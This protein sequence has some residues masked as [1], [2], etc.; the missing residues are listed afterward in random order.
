MVEKNTPM[1]F[2]IAQKKSVIVLSRHMDR[3][4]FNT[5]DNKD[6]TTLLKIIEEEKVPQIQS[7]TCFFLPLKFTP[8]LRNV[9]IAHINHAMSQPQLYLG[10]TIS[11]NDATQLHYR[12][13]G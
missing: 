9:Y 6:T 2:T 11:L 10:I 3:L 12:P 7:S 8:K 1:R 13:H 4:D 5:P